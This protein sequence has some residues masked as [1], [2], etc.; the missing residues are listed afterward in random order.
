[1]FYSEEKIEEVREKNDIVDVISQYV[2][3][4]RRGG[5]Y[6]GLCPFHNDRNPSFAVNREKQSYYC[7]GC[8]QGGSVF[9]FLREYSGLDFPEAMKE[10][11]ARAGVD[12]PVEERTGR[13]RQEAD[14]RTL[15]REMNRKSAVY[16]HYLLNGPRGQRAMDYLTGRGLSPETIRKFGLGYADI[17]RDD[18]Y[19]YLK[20]EG[21]SD[22]SLK[23][24]SLVTVDSV[25]GSYDTF[26]NRVMFPIMDVNQ[27]VVGFGGRVMGEGE[28]KYL[29]SKETILFE[30]SRHLYGLNY[31]RRSRERA[32]L[33]CE[34]Y[35]DVISLHQAG[36]TNAAAPLGTAFTPGQARLL[37]R[38][39]DEVILSFDSDEAGVK[40][41]LRALPILR[42]GGLKAR[43]LTMDPYKD[44]DELIKAKGAEEYRRRMEQAEPGRMF[45]MIQI[46]NRYRRDDPQENIDFIRSL[47]E[48]LAKIEDPTEFRVYNA[49]AARR[50]L[51]PEEE[52]EK[53][54]DHFRPRIQHQKVNDAYKAERKTREDRQKE[55][56]D[57]QMKPHR[58]LLTWLTEHPEIYPLIRPY[59][60]ADDFLPPLYHAAA[61]MVFTRLEQ[62][63]DVV[64]GSIIDRFED[65]EEQREV[66]AMFHDSI[67][68]GDAPENQEKALTDVV[69][70]VCL[71]G[72]EEKMLHI[73]DVKQWG[74][75]TEQRRKLEKLEFHLH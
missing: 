68:C 65:P 4:Q 28:P 56:E 26:F 35:M 21:Y 51:I 71:A 22:L 3:L 31:A 70:K 2:S 20:K 39:T 55:R 15:L 11:A 53:E 63:R 23:D 64:P 12:L 75:I 29:N 7:H 27:K 16:F 48:Y 44:P 32:L 33:L 6:V 66:A 59:V 30:K 72:M 41:I 9:T 49:S 1:M 8:H 73:T 25:K 18:L 5:E 54:A 43:V 74:E 10:L 34:G 45:E 62:G 40:A 52:L 50:F 60:S 61:G 17:Y 46:E 37:K 14:A 57:N 42:E 38:Y 58:V 69:R 47:G 67:D 19:Q 13:E 24:S 36:F